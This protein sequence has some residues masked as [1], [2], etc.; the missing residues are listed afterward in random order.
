M[1]CTY[2]MRE[3]LRQASCTLC[4]AAA[5]AAAVAPSRAAE[6]EAPQTGRTALHGH[7]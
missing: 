6:A 5:N 2:V 7:G 1:G 4:P 3:C